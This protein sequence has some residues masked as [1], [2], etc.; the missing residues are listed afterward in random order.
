MTEKNE[1]D[2]HQEDQYD[3]PYHFI[4]ELAADNTITTSRFLQ[5]AMVYMGYI[6]FVTDVVMESEATSVLD[7]GCGDGRI[8]YELEQRNSTKDYLG[9]DI[10]PRALNFARGFAPQ[11]SFSVFDIVE[12]PYPQAY[13]L[14]TFVETIEHIEPTQIPTMIAHIA[15]SLKPGGTLL[16]TT[17]TTNVPTHVK[18]YQ[19]FDRALLEQYLGDHFTITEVRYFNVENWLAKTLARL[20]VN[21][22]YTCNLAFVRRA[23]NNLYRAH[24]LF[25]SEKTG[26]RI[27]IRATKK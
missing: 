21:K 27:Y 20:L 3:F 17:P 19:H 24:C 25:G 18:H 9:L 14:C 10:S 8:A 2:Q 6:S 22:I 11:S 7:V 12:K 5:W 23:V 1:K 13:D 26:S 16:L 15:A 4:P